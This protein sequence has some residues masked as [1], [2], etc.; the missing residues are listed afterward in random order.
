MYRVSKQ[1]WFC[2]AHQVRL[3][4]TRCEALHGHNYRVLVH[5]E[6]KQLDKT[7]YVIDFAELKKAAVEICA[8]FDHGNINEIEPFAKGAKSHGRGA[9]PVSVRA[10]RAKVRRRARA[11]LQSRGL[12]DRQQPRGIH[13]MKNGVGRQHAGFTPWFWSYRLAAK[14]EAVVVVCVFA[15]VIAIL[16]L[17]FRMPGPLVVHIQDD[18]KEPIIGA[19]VSCTSPDGMTTHSGTTDVFGEA[20]WP[21][22]AKGPWRCDVTPP[23]RFHASVADRPHQRGRAEA[24]DVD[25]R[26]RASGPDHG[27]GHPPP[28]QPRAK[29][30]VRAVCGSETWEGRA[31]LLDGLATLYAPHGKPC[32]VGLVRP[33]LPGDGPVTEAKLQCAAAPC[34]GEMTAG[35]GQQIDIV[36]TPPRGVGRDQTSAGQAGDGRALIAWGYFPWKMSIT[37]RRSWIASSRAAGRHYG[38]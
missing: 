32:R 2:A 7:S 29:V 19:R 14:F 9:G 31:G 20:K 3:S 11:G 10:A 21:G 15:G 6:A 27:A 13:A 26:G 22:L 1:L 30:A 12:G 34:T 36:L 17:L 25:H 8:R 28:G 38:P 5:A 4:E 18:K 23:D 24:R 33:E 16:A 37:W 35:V